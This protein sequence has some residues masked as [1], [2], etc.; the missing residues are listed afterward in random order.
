[1]PLAKEGDAEAQNYVGEIYEKGLGLTPDYQLAAMWYQKASD[2]QFTR[3]QINLGHLYEKGL[4]VKKSIATAMSFYRLA[5][6]LTDDQLTFSSS[7]QASYVP[8]EQFH[9]ISQQLRQTETKQQELEE[10]VNLFQNQLVAKNNS[11]KENEQQLKNTQEQLQALL[12]NAPDKASGVSTERELEL[13]DELKSLEEQRTE[14]VSQVSTIEDSAK[15]LAE[16]NRSLQSQLEK[17]IE[18][19]TKYRT[20][21]AK[22][23]IELDSYARQLNQTQQEVAQLEGELNKQRASNN[24]STTAGKST[25]SSLERAIEKKN[26]IL[27]VQTQQHN[28]LLAQRNNEQSELKALRAKLT[29][30]Q[31]ALS[32]Q[33]TAAK[34]QAEYYK[35]VLSQ[36][37]H[38]L[39]DIRGQ[40]HANQQKLQQALDEKQK[41]IESLSASHQ[42][43]T[44][45]FEAQVANLAKQLEQQ[46]KLVDSQHQQISILQKDID[47]YNLEIIKIASLTPTA[48]GP[49]V[50]DAPSIEIIDPPVT[51]TRSTPTVNL[52]SRQNHR[53]IIGKV[54][55]PAG[56]LSL[57]INGINEDLEDN[58]LFKA[59]VPI[60]DDI[61]PV[62]IVAVDTK[63]RRVAIS[64]SM[65]S[66]TK[67]TDPVKT[68]TKQSPGNPPSLGN[69]YALIIGNNDYQSM[70]TLVTAI[71]DAKE[72]ERILKNQ[73]QFKTQLL[74]NATRYQILSALNK[75]REDLQ[76]NDNLLIYY[77]GHGKLDPINKRGFLATY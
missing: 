44:G 29:E 40:L 28:T 19:E 21:I 68:E 45:E 13:L 27:T 51:L 30:Q 33:T 20:Q 56:L 66:E 18:S 36:K 69:Y 9:A 5:S 55:A 49:L 23:Q 41:E 57:T 63:G 26:A 60:T 38:A 77:A 65:L 34:E 64:F 8:R 3:A 24:A 58:S 53:D 74:V 12:I 37:E 72:A 22:T 59:E 14:L 10:K 76:E 48:A 39:A 43:E 2:Q 6:G 75:L 67:N 7:L 11:L 42:T 54:S 70:S 50:D 61:T 32:Q 47:N 31:R 46:Q 73:Y 52:R 15:L 17:S 1:M 16:K 62:D 71:N 35:D 4:G 25:I